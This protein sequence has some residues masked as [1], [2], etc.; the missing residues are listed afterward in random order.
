[1][2]QF[3]KELRQCVELAIINELEISDSGVD[4]FG[5]TNK[6]SRLLAALVKE[7]VVSREDI[8]K[9]VHV[10]LLKI[11]RTCYEQ[12]KQRRQYPDHTL[13]PSALAYALKHGEITHSEATSIKFDH[14]ETVET[15]IEIYERGIA[16]KVLEQLLTEREPRKLLDTTDCCESHR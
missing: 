2:H 13:S 5:W 14:G 9:W 16:E 12:H 7:T 1:M 15:F 11:G 10:R 6:H 4:E 3:D 8:S